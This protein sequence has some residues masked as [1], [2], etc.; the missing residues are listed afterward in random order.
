MAKVAIP[1]VAV[2]PDTQTETQPEIQPEIQQ[3]EA[4]EDV[5]V[6]AE[7]RRLVVRLLGG[8]EI[9]L[10]SFDERDDAMDAAQQ[11]VARFSSAEASGDWPEVDGRFLR[12]G[13]VAS[14]DVLVA[15]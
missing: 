12:P 3:E 8:D 14:I 15:G 7:V 5:P 10:G 9:E 6:V 11:L 2:E 13:S 1:A 4:H